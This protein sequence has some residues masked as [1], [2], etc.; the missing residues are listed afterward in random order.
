LAVA[1]ST[2]IGKG[3]ISV[4]WKPFMIDPNTQDGGEDYMAYNRRRWGG[5]GWTHHL[6]QEGRKDGYGA[7]FNDWK[8]WPNTFKAHQLIQYAKECDDS[9]SDNTHVWNRILMEEIYENGNNISLVDQLVDLGVTKF[10]IS[11]SHKKELREY[12][13]KNNGGKQVKQE[14]KEGQRKYRISGVPFFIISKTDGNQRPYG[15]SGAQAKDTFAEIFQE[16]LE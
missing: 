2:A 13:A 16:F 1:G 8:I 5:D 11:E 15:L 10:G 14:I 3:V 7:N 9:N 4:E 12:L 6:R